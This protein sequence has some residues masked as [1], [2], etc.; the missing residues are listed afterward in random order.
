M[1]KPER[2]NQ[3]KLPKQ[4]IILSYTLSVPFYNMIK[5]INPLLTRSNRGFCKF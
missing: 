3:R 5:E 4:D 2:S 1:P